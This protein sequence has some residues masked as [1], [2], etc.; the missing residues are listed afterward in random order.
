MFYS[1]DP[2]YC[3]LLT[4][5]DGIFQ[6][7]VNDSVEVLGSNPARRL[8]FEATGI[9]ND[10]ARFWFL[11]NDWGENRPSDWMAGTLLAIHSGHPFTFVKLIVLFF[12]DRCCLLLFNVRHGLG[13]S[14]PKSR[15][16]RP[17]CRFSASKKSPGGRSVQLVA[18]SMA[19]GHGQSWNSGFSPPRCHSSFEPKK[20]ARWEKTFFFLELI[21]VISVKVDGTTT[22]YRSG[23]ARCR[24]SEFRKQLFQT[25]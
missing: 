17:R 20:N 14:A 4:I 15:R 18:I 21:L 24:V 5:L 7:Q 16:A 10:L 19:K 13:R 3:G 22:V 23:Q 11:S 6:L 2:Y 8:C 9:R 25:P 12:R 1:S